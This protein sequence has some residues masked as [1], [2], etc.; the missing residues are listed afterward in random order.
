MIRTISLFLIVLNAACQYE[1]R[2]GGD[3]KATKD[4]VSWSA[5]ATAVFAPVFGDSLI[6]VLGKVYSEQGFI[7]EELAF[8]KIPP[9]EGI[10]EVFIAG[11]PHTYKGIGVAYSIF[12]GDGHVISEYQTVD[13]SYQNTF[14]VEAYDVS[15]RTLKAS[16][17]CRMMYVDGSND[18][19]Y[20]LFKNGSIDVVIEDY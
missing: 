18:T 2:F 20:T 10:C 12:E 14:T 19:T 15:S 8:F 17:E 3:I 6:T 7:R 13:T 5:R 4:Q 9:R 16:F 1:V 11:A